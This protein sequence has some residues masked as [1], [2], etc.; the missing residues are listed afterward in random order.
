MNAVRRT[1]LIP[2]HLVDWMENND[3]HTKT[4][5]IVKGLQVISQCNIERLERLSTQLG[6]TI[7]KTIDMALHCLEQMDEKERLQN[8]ITY[9][10]KM[11][12]EI[13]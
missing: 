3:Q 7:G 8:T 6:L 2:K 4:E 9:Y 12:N 10:D 13:K 11:R 1:Y 5:A